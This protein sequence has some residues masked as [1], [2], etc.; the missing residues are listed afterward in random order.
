MPRDQVGN[1]FGI[2][3]TVRVVDD[4]TM[5]HVCGFV[6]ANQPLSRKAIKAIAIAACAGCKHQPHV[7]YWH[8]V[9]VVDPRNNPWKDHASH[10]DFCYAD[11]AQR[12]G[13]AI[14]S[15]R[16]KARKV[17]RKAV[18][19]TADKAVWGGG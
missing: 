9:V 13:L 6:V 1:P 14:P 8:E 12:D 5:F 4:G 15:K 7:Y 16:T 2:G 18:A 10:T 11:V 19:D 3:T 17:I